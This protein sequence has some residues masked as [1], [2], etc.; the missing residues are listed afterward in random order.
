M[1]GAELKLETIE[2]GKPTRDGH[3]PSV[4]DEQVKRAVAGDDLR[5]EA[6]DGPQVGQVEQTE[7]HVRFRDF[8]P[9]PADRLCAPGL[10]TGR[11][12]H[13]SAGPA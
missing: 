12:H 8:G 4:V 13:A 10:V 6:A 11:H 3:D 1:V 5:G 2:G 9:D 7:L